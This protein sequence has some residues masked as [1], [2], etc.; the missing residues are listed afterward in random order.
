MTLRKKQNEK[1]ARNRHRNKSK[2]CHWKRTLR[3]P[4]NVYKQFHKIVRQTVEQQ[5]N[6]STMIIIIDVFTADST[7]CCCRRCGHTT[8]WPLTF[9][10]L[11]MRT[12]YIYIMKRANMHP[13]TL[14]IHLLY[15]DF[16]CSDI[17]TLAVQTNK[18]PVKKKPLNSAHVEQQN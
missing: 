11:A 5:E 7:G 1:Q 3:L 14:L 9:I 10:A 8:N 6:P 16:S 17:R 12:K 2:H 15:I 4:I 13:I 18:K